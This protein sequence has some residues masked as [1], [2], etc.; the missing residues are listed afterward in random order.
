MTKTRRGKQSASGA[1]GHR[2]SDGSEDE[3]DR[4]KGV[5][6]IETLLKQ[7]VKLS[8]TNFVKI[9]AVFKVF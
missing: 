8:L 6:N 9:C 3:Q 5:G 4:S 1:G 2:D 7:V